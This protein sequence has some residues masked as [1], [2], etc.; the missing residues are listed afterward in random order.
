M[1]AEAPIMLPGGKLIFNPTPEEV[2]RVELSWLNHNRI[3]RE[4]TMFWIGCAV[5]ALAV[6]GSA[7]CL[8]GALALSGTP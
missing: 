8:F 4:N 5:V 2:R 1:T 3:R 7:A 6:L